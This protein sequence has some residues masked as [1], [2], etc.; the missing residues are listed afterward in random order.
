MTAPKEKLSDI[1]KK[2]MMW[3]IEANS[4]LELLNVSDKKV[5]GRFETVSGYIH[6]EHLLDDHENGFH[7]ETIEQDCP[8]CTKAVAEAEDP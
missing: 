5:S 4:A 1:F 8:E 6:V 3:F 7:A 2:T